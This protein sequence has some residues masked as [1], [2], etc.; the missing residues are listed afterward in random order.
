MFVIGAKLRLVGGKVSQYNLKPPHPV[1]TENRE[2]GPSN[3]LQL[4]LTFTMCSEG[5]KV[6]LQ[7]FR[8]HGHRRQDKCYTQRTTLLQRSAQ[9]GIPV[10]NV[11]F[12][13]KLFK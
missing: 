9:Y 6:K 2:H 4:S 10:R 13:R 12:R 1:I 7:S 5:K 3:Q 8:R 11:A